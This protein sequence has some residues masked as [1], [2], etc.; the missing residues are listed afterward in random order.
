MVTEAVAKRKKREEKKYF[1]RNIVLSQ[2]TQIQYM[3]IQ[4]HTLYKGYVLFHNIESANRYLCLA[5]KLNKTQWHILLGC[6]I[7]CVHWY[8]LHPRR[9][10]VIPRNASRVPYNSEM[11]QSCLSLPSAWPLSQNCCLTY[12]HTQ[13]LLVSWSWRPPSWFDIT[14]GERALM[15][16]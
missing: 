16:S 10:I 12:C 6:N 4:I 11:L 7:C 15:S 13:T 14:E 3:H 8:T 1:Y 5:S 2:Y 9:R